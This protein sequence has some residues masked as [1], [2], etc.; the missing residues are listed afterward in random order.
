MDSSVSMSTRVPYR[1]KISPLIAMFLRQGL[2]RFVDEPSAMR[3]R[4]PIVARNAH[5]GQSH[6]ERDPSGDRAEGGA[7]V[8][9]VARVF[10]KKMPDEGLRGPSVVRVLHEKMLEFAHDPSQ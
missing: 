9:E 5:K 7:T 6:V 8:G 4:D 3:G 10:P 2:D 1:S